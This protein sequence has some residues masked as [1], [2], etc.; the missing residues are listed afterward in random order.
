MFLLNYLL[1]EFEETASI[2][3]LR[4]IPDLFLQL[5]FDKKP[6]INFDPIY[7]LD[8]GC[9]ILKLMLLL[10]LYFV[11]IISTLQINAC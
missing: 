11:I 6:F 3:V 5:E 10:S 9:Y 8:M 2:I 1:H 4:S 7:K